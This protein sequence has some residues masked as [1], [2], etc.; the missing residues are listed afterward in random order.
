MTRRSPLFC[1]LALALACAPLL[2]AE[3]AD[4]TGHWE[5]T[6]RTPRM[7]TRME[8]DLAKT[9]AGNVVGTFT[10]P[11][12]HV[13][14]LPMTVRMDGRMIEMST[15]TDQVVI[16]ELSADGASIEATWNINGFS[17]PFTMVRTGDPRIEPPSRIAAID[18]ELVGSWNGEVESDGRQ[19]HLVLILANHPDGTATGHVVN[20]DEG[21][22]M[23][24]VSAIRQA[25]S[26]LTLEFKAIE[27]IFR[28]KLSAAGTELVGTLRQGPASLPVIFTRSR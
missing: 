18:A 24:P 25:A 27:S 20:V 16:G 8:M 4:P 10:S 5:G 13:T 26:E 6:L 14:G 3:S 28:G 21:N 9:A 17:I 22:Q 12:E 7:E 23:I 1:A 15:R 11:A 2:G 19:L